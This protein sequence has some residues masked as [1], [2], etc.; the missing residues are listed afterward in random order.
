MR[1]DREAIQCAIKIAP[2]ID[3]DRATIIRI[4]DTLHLSEIRVSENMM[5]AMQGVAGLERIG[6]PEDWAFDAQGNLW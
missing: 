2:G 5:E 6:E 4:A 3:R 1:N